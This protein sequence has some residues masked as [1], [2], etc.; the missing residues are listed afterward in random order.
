VNFLVFDPEEFLKFAEILFKKESLTET[1]A[2]IIMNRCYY[3][4]LL[5]VQ[6]SK[7]QVKCADYM[8]HHDLLQEMNTIDTLLG[9]LVSRLFSYRIVADYSLKKEDNHAKIKVKLNGNFAEES[10]QCAQSFKENFD[11]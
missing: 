11:I 7:N 9:N 4:C 8:K 2:R 5:T 10:I 6:K 1:D 3:Y